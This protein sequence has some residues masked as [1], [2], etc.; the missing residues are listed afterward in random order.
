MKHL[1]M[2]RAIERYNGIMFDLCADHLTIG[3]PAYSE[4]TDGWNL[5]DMVAECDYLLSTYYDPNHNNGILRYDDDEECRKAW[6]S[7]T[8]KLERFIKAYEPFVTDMVCT[9]G[10]C[11]DRYD[12]EPSYMAIVKKTGLR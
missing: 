1:N 4:G 7:E 8:G 2:E 5:R 3:V 11:S 12:N 6:R 9:E 10:H